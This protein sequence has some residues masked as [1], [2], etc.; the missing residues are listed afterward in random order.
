MAAAGPTH[1][2]A[3]ESGVFLGRKSE[4]SRFREAIRKRES[5]LVW[6]ASDSGKSVLVARALS[7][8]P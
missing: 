4:L 6:G 1:D 5:L 7:R 8:T 3:L 2:V